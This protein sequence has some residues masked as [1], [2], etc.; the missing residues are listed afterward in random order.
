MILGIVDLG[1]NNLTSVQNS[2]APT[3]S[4]VDEVVIVSSSK[5]NRRPDLVV[6]PGLGKFAT[7]MNALNRSGLA[8]TIKEWHLLG[9]KIVGICLGMQL[10][11]TS[12]QESEGVRGLDLIQGRVQILPRDINERVPNIGWASLDMV[13]SNANFPSL[14]SKGDLYFVHSYHL[15]PL[16]EEKILTKTTFGNSSFVSSVV[17]KNIL[18]VQFHPEK[19]GQKGKSLIL[20]IMQWAQNEI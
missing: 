9:S 16:K 14:D 13:Q 8:D 2:F 15:V 5:C 17:D 10:L 18:G 4:V 7:G 11:G 1:I 3:P 6:I 20:E 19:S 12:S